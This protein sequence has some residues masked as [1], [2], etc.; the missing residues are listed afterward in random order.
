MTKYIRTDISTQHVFSR[1]RL[2]YIAS[3]EADL[4]DL[5]EEVRE[6][7]LTELTIARL[8]GTPPNMKPWKGCGSGVY[9]LKKDHAGDTYR[10]VYLV[11]FKEAMYVLH[12]F[13]KKSKSGIKTPSPDI[14]GATAA[15][16]CREAL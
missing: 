15:E 8:G 13:Q 16:S 11:R 10:A 6:E 12:V 4:E 14:Q 1:R 7:L 5:P 2:F 3:A 9:E